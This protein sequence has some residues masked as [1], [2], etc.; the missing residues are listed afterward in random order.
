M[1]AVLSYNH[2][3]LSHVRAIVSDT[4]LA[5][6]ARPPLLFSQV[7]T[8]ASTKTLRLLSLLP[9]RVHLWTAVTALPQFEESR[10]LL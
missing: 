10:K 2:I 8:V 6:H 7:A 3:I 9:N 5:K 4:Q 1:G